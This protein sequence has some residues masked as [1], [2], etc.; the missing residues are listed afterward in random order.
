MKNKYYEGFSTHVTGITRHGK[1]YWVKK[2]FI[3][4]LVKFKPV[5]VFDYKGE[6]SGPRAID[7]DKKWKGYSNIEA[8]VASLQKTQVLTKEVHVIHARENTDFIS[9]LSLLSYLR[10]QVSIVLDEAQFIF[11]DPKLSAAREKLIK[12]VRAGAGD[13]ADVIMISQRTMDMP[14]DIRSQ[15]T[16]RITF[17]QE[18]SA[19]IDVMYKDNGFVEAEK[20]R[21]LGKREY[22][23]LGHFPEHLG[24]QLA[25]NSKKTE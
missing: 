9:G 4:L 10:L 1:S 3:P 7:H 5:I 22:L 11:M 18:S 15:F 8:F 19:D 20:A 24:K 2:V 23:V 21:S 12:L 25:Q 14:L 16:R 17:R 6:Y 13:G